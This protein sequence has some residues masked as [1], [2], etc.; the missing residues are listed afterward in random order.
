MSAPW[1]ITKVEPREDY[2]LHLTFADGTSGEIDMAPRLWGKVFEP[3][4]NDVNLFRAVYIDEVARTIAW[5][6]DLDYAPDALHDDLKVILSGEPDPAT[7][8]VA[9]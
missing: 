8:R 1:S 9:R 3:L 5:S 2:V 7:Q 4:R 6:E